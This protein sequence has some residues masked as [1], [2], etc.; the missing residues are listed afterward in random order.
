[1]HTAPEIDLAQLQDSLQT[2]YAVRV[3][4]LRFFPGGEDGFGYRVVTD[5]GA[6]YFLK[7]YNRD[8]AWEAVLKI[9]AWLNAQG[10]NAVAALPTVDDSLSITVE[11]HQAALYPFIDGD[12]PMAVPP[13]DEEWREVGRMLA[14]LHQ[15]T[16]RESIPCPRETFDTSWRHYFQ[17]IMQALPAATKC[18][19]QYQREL[20][21]LMLPIA[22]RLH[23]EL[24]HFEHAAE[25]ARAQD[26]PYVLC[27][28]DPTIANWIFETDSRILHLIDWDGVLLAP[29]E[30]DLGHFFAGN[31]ELVWEGYA[32]I[33]GDASLNPVITAFYGVQW[34]IQE[35]VDYGTKLLF[36]AQSP[37]QNAYD[38]NEMHE[39]LGYSGLING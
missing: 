33:T 32:E 6:T 10:V 14:H 12:T 29:K 37:E 39:F 38:L 3:R 27:H 34:N 1:M 24:A 15:T 16:L 30:R 35:I 5:T 25:N 36:Q 20:A 7:V 21:H 19:N 26:V 2:H 11:N 28:H 31:Q 23:E 18:E 17:R 9:P 4:E 8:L 22:D 13:S